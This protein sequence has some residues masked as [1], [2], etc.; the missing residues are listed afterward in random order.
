MKSYS[1]SDKVIRSVVKEIKNDSIAN[2]ID[3]VK[4]NSVALHVGSYD[5]S[6]GTENI[7]TATGIFSEYQRL[8]NSVCLRFHDPQIVVSSIPFRRLCEN[9]T[10]TVQEEYILIN[11]E[12]LKLNQM[13]HALS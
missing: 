10:D 8:L 7:P 4:V 6:T 11:S 3:S 1:T 12:I 5:W 13:L 2:D 9:L